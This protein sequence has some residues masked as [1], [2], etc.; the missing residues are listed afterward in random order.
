MGEIYTF[1]PVKLSHQLKINCNNERNDQGNDLLPSALWGYA[2]KT[3]GA[4]KPGYRFWPCVPAFFEVTLENGCVF[5]DIL[6]QVKKYVIE[7]SERMT[8]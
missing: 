5:F 2:S 6:L 1:V 3:G 7:N 8:L 4:A